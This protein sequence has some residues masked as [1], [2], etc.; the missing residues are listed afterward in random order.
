MRLPKPISRDG[1]PFLFHQQV[2]NDQKGITEF[3]KVLRQ[4]TK[5]TIGQCLFCLE[6]TGIYN[7]PL[8]KKLHQL[9]A[10][11]WIER[12]VHIQESIGLTRG[13]TDQIDAKRIALFAYKN[14]D[15]ARLWTPPRPVIAQL[16]GWPLPSIN[17]SAGSPDKGDQNTTDPLNR[18]GGFH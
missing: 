4:Q 5:A 11:I 2:S 17:C 12:A 3:L 8:L 6:F 1:G 13:K 7:N 15:E 14:R 16:D 9:S 10:F 18:L